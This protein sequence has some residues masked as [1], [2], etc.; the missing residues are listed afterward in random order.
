MP[1]TGT[2]HGDLAALAGVIVASLPDPVLAA[3]APGLAADLGRHPGVAERFRQ[4]LIA[5]EQAQGAEILQ[6]AV[7]RGELPHEPVPAPVHANVPGTVFARTFLF[8]R[9]PGPEP[10]ARLAGLTAAGL[11]SLPPAAD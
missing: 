2:L 11:R 6:R 5:A 8:H 1:D 4:T 10:A 7:A 3:V 9:H